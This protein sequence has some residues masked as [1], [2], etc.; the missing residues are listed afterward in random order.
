MSSAAQPMPGDNSDLPVP[1]VPVTEI[2]YAV[3]LALTRLERDR[4]HVVEASAGTGKTYLIEHRVVDL[5]L[6]TETAIEQILVVTFTERATAELRFRIRRLIEAVSS[7][8]DHSAGPDEPHWLIDQAA[9]RTLRDALMSF[10]RAAIYTIHAFCQRVLTE[11]AFANR[12]L[13]VQTQVATEEAFAQAF[14]AA[15]RETFARQ[16]PQRSYLAAWL[17]SGRDVDA[18]ENLL[19]RCASQRGRLVPQHDDGAITELLDRAASQ[20]PG[21]GPGPHLPI[22]ESSLAGAL[23]NAGVH[24]SS[25]KA[26][27]RRLKCLGELLNRWT[28]HRE[29]PTFLADVEAEDKALRAKVR[30]LPYLAEKLG[31]AQPTTLGPSNIEILALRSLAIELE[32]TVVPLAA[33]IAQMFLPEVTRRME[34]EKSRR[35]YFDFHDMLSLVWDSLRSDSADGLITRL[36]GRYRHALI[37]EF[38]DTDEL[39]WKIFRRLYLDTD[40]EAGA[41]A[42]AESDADATPIVRN[43]LCIIGDPKQAIYGFR[44]ADVYTYLEARKHVRDVGGRVTN[45]IDNYR[46]T[47]ALVRA[48]NTIFEER[49]GMGFFT[50]DIRYDHPVRAAT[51]LEARTAGGQSIA[52]ICLF[53][54]KPPERGKLRADSVRATLLRRIAAEI[55]SILYDPDA[56]IHVGTPDELTP[57]EAGDIFILTRT[58]GESNEVAAC[59]R[60]AAIPCAIYKQ[61]GLF[62]SREAKEVRDL[63]SGIVE[64]RSRSARF[65]AWTTRFFGVTLSDLPH[66]SA[67]P[68]THSL[69][70]R[71][72]EWKTLADK[73]A[74]EELFARIIDDSGVIERELFLDTS[75]RSL[76]NF[77][78]LFE[79]LLEEVMRSRCTLHELVQRLNRWI[80][81]TADLHTDDRNVQRLESEKSAVQIMTIH[82]SKGLE[83][84]VV[85]VYGGLGSYP[86]DEVQ[87]YHDG[88]ERLVHVGYAGSGVER[89]VGREVESEDQRL[90]YVALTRAAARLYLPYVDPDDYRARGSYGR[91]LGR[92]ET[93]VRALRSGDEALSHLFAI[94]SVSGSFTQPAGASDQRAAMEEWEPPGTLL[95]NEEEQNACSDEAR[96]RRAGF[97]VTSYTRMKSHGSTR[98]P[99]TA[100]DFKAD[101]AHTSARLPE[102]Q[103]PGGAQS[104]VFLHN[105]LEHIDFASAADGISFDEWRVR[106]EILGLFRRAMLRHNRDPQHLLYSQGVI[107]NCLTTPIALGRKTLPNLASR[108]R[109]M[110]EVEF[111]YPIPTSAA[112]RAELGLGQPDDATASIAARLGDSIRLER[113]YV[114]GFIDLVFE[115]Q[116]RVYAVD[117]KSDILPEYSGKTL[118]RHVFHEYQVQTELYCLALSKTLE[119]KTDYQHRKRFGGLLYC[120]IRGVGSSA[121]SDGRQAGVYYIRPN[122]AKLSELERALE[123]RDDYR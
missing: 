51:Q 37:D 23:K 32:R 96:S 72:F 26:V 77:L 40:I 1:P 105:V 71:L 64:P 47:D 82:R 89:L 92:L 114:K 10:D 31:A 43:R 86:G 102:N 107:F 17:R 116:G 33:A 16:E 83:A 56:A 22:D 58:V 45:L 68:E 80:A 50:G 79:I 108:F 101:I 2:R 52:P 21:C 123:E 67:L 97:V 20:L 95:Q 117:W 29:I 69:I 9:R 14:K 93:I 63:L 54:V 59:L 94:D 24:P 100:V 35:G 60:Q 7:A 98:V 119:L 48:Y 27:I 61:E 121:T 75:E 39:Q 111:L 62:Q 38:Q 122:F 8:C 90:L 55:R 120:F 28:E 36:R 84:R 103:L 53:H 65:Q 30:I 25:V 118:A 12:R 15:L 70:A 91:L 112:T 6:T 66:L 104:G 41:E 44:G 113:G 3:P 34:E 42:G 99:L 110:R 88:G 109:I 76:T 78:H 74:Y 18:L 81:D 19:Y 106:P 73:L 85:F 13:F 87:V 11:N 46:S 49:F 4:H 5:L 57:V 115:F